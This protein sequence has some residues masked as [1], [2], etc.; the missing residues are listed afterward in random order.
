[1]NASIT[2]SLRRMTDR[3][4][5]APDIDVFEHA[6]INVAV[7]LVFRHAEPARGLLVN[8]LSL[9]ANYQVAPPS[10][11]LARRKAAGRFSIASATKKL[12]RPRPDRVRVMTRQKISARKIAAIH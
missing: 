5:P 8:R 9:D 7:D 6:I 3:L 2:D 12:V 11:I 4:F 1:M 10:P